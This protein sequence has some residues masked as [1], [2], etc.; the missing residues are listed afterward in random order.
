MDLNKVYNFIRIGWNDPKKD[1][2]KSNCVKYARVISNIV[3]NISFH[4]QKEG[5]YS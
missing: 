5:A 3:R 2:G 4:I 1:S